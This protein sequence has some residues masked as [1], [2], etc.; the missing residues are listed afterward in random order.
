MPSKAAIVLVVAIFL[1]TL[2]VRLPASVISELLPRDV[3]CREP[4]GTVWQGA[5]AELHSGSLT[6]SD[7]H[8]SL[9]PLALLRAHLRLDL[10][11]GDVRAPGRATLSLDTHGDADIES[12]IATLPLQNGIDVLPTGWSGAIE[13]AIPRARIESHHLTSIEGTI[14]A[15]QLHCLRPAADL[16]SFELSFPPSGLQAPSVGSL[17]DIGGPL[18][19]QGSLRLAG[20]GS[21]E[22][23]AVVAARDPANADLQQLLL[24][25]GPPDAQGQHALSLAGTL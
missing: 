3:D 22:M 21:Y 25:L 1:V 15:R 18:A 19:L 24:L 16:G 20:D 17:H 10:Q 11:S 5:C 12:L 23:N 4:S 8:W 13:L 6:L 7:L 14:T 9:H 2:L